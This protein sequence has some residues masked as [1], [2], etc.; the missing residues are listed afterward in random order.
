MV[1][2][3]WNRGYFILSL[4]CPPIMCIHFASTMF[5][6]QIKFECMIT[7]I[8]R[9]HQIISYIQRSVENTSMQNKGRW[10]VCM[11]S[12]AQV[13]TN[14]NSLLYVAIGSWCVG[15]LL[16]SF[17]GNICKFKPKIKAKIVTKILKTFELIK[18]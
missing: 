6:L 1:C 7:F 5:I 3:L 15:V 12:K 9:H 8:M 4:Q 17:I 10:E 18:K 2:L 11:G 14:N 13:T 16:C